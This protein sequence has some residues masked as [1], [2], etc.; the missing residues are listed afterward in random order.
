M[1]FVYL[2]NVNSYKS[3]SKILKSLKS[4]LLAYIICKDLGTRR[5]VNGFPEQYKYI[6][7]VLYRS[8]EL[9]LLE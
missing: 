9:I 4:E 6:N 2:L 5:D 8:N 7:C 1:T 3:V